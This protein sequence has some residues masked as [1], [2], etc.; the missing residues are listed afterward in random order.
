MS[1]SSKMTISSLRGSYCT[2]STILTAVFSTILI[3][4]LLQISLKLTSST[5]LIPYHICRV[6]EHPTSNH[7]AHTTTPSSP[8]DIS[9]T[10]SPSPNNAATPTTTTHLTTPFL[11]KQ[12]HVLLNLSHSIDSE[13]HARLLPP[14]TG[15]FW[16]RHNETLNIAMG[17][18]MFHANHCLLFLRST[19]QDHIEG[20]R[21]SVVHATGKNEY[22]YGP[23]DEGDEKTHLQTHVAHCFSYIAQQ[24]MCLGDSTIEPPWIDA[25]A[26]GNIQAFGIDGH[27]VHHQCKDMTRMVAMAR[28][29]QT[30]TFEDWGWKDGDTVESVFGP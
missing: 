27:G 3:V 30:E 22:G 16:T 28:R 18:S 14:R 25:D 11:F 23:H 15:V 10:P 19:L 2:P 29:G 4:L 8:P 13:V 1:S 20:R 17:I 12:N 6:D 7:P 21:S 9:H 26:A 24:I 5:P